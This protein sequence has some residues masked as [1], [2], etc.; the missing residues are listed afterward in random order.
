[1]KKRIIICG[2]PKSGNTWLT[3]LI[4]E[5]V[6][7][8]V[9]GFWAEPFNKDI[10][11]EGKERISDY[12]CFK[13][14]HSI[15]QLQE[16][17]D[18]YGNGTEK[19]IYIYRDPRDVVV[20][21]SKFFGIPP[22]FKILHQFLSNVP[23]GLRLYYSLF[24]EEEYKISKMVDAIL[25]GGEEYP[26]WLRIPWQEHVQSYIDSSVL[27]VRY[28]DL[29]NDCVSC[30]YAILNHLDFQ[31]NETKVFEAVKNQSFNKKKETFVE[32]NEL[33]KAAFL[34]KGMSGEWKK[35]LS[36]SQA[37]LFQNQ[38]GAFLNSLGYK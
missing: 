36:N 37:V 28:E 27:T 17:L 8:P 26:K 30:A 34:R 11:I 35:K 15:D 5:L 21:S 23:T 24:N 19:V 20:S 16:T 12:E 33:S 3:R 10:A 18:I 4:A 6:D 31:T 32:N 14:H 13:S 25:Y 7:C 1:M 9:T 2:Y 22:R 29:L 38:I